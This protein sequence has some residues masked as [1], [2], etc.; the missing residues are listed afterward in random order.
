[1]MCPT[2]AEISRVGC[3]A[4]HTP[5]RSTGRIR[6]HA[7]FIKLSLCEEIRSPPRMLQVSTVMP[8]YDVGEDVIIRPLRAFHIIVS[9]CSLSGSPLPWL[10]KIFFI[11]TSGRIAYGR[12]IR[13]V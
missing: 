9:F 10:T 3:G 4:C 7:T 1:M 6:V 5:P 2:A 13:Y 11:R 12:L 8:A